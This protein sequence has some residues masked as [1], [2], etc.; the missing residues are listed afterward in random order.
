MVRSPSIRLPG[1]TALMAAGALGIALASQFLG[2]LQPCEL[3]L[4]QRWPWLVALVLALA[5][6]AL[7]GARRVLTVLA[8]IAVLASGAIA[9]FHVGVEY[10]W[11]A[12]LPGCSGSMTRADSIDALRATLEAQPIVPCDR[13]AWSFA[14]ISMAG[15]NFIAALV[16]G[17]ITLVGAA[18]RS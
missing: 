8:G 16:V 1:F 14:G 4:M 18:R 3:C 9:L 6:V 13:A 11:W 2:G 10:H 17:L 15:F 5:A 7:P 12:G